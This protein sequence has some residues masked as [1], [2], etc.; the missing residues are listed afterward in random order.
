L[1]ALMRDGHEPVIVDVRSASSVDLDGRSIPG[2][3]R[4]QL[5][6]VSDKARELPRG[7]EIVLYCNCPNEVTAARAA[8]MLA[9]Q[10]LQRVRPLAGGLEA[11]FE[12]AEGAQPMQ[13]SSPR[14]SGLALD[15]HP[16]AERAHEGEAGA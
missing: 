9:A 16:S 6:E 4:M 13:G 3:L 15:Q 11:W 2:A 5:D 14:R 10:G 1:R 7:R 8:R 12:S